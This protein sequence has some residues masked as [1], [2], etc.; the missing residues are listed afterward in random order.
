MQKKKN[1]D[2]WVVDVELIVEKNTSAPLAEEEAKCNRHVVGIRFSKLFIFKKSCN[3]IVFPAGG[4]KD[5]K[6]FE[7]I[8]IIHQIVITHLCR[9]WKLFC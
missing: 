4:G 5:Q 8:I 9:Y 7:F 1:G 3:K 2:E 6:I